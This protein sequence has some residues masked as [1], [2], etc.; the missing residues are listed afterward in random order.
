MKNVEAVAAPDTAVK[1]SN[2]SYWGLVIRKFRKNRLAIVSLWIL[3]IIVLLCIFVPL[4][5]PYGM[6]QTDALSREQPP[7]AAHWLGTDKIGRDMFTR[8]FYGGRI[9]LGVSLSVTGIQCFIG[10][11][12]GSIAGYYG[13]MADTIIMR[14]CEIFMSFPFMIMCIT[15]VAVFGSS[16]RTLI[17]ALAILQWPNIARIVRGQIL[18]LREQEYMEACEALGI[19]DFRRIFRHLFPNVLAYVI[20]YATLGMASAILVETSLSFLGLGV[21]PPTPTWG[22]MIT[23]AKDLL[24][25][26]NKWWYWIPPGIC[27]FLSVMCFNILGDGLRDAIDPKMKR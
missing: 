10:I 4:I 21:A 18:V 19:S 2:E 14:L 17:F 22:N 6:E 16:V 20:V 13:K 27:I 5:S 11:I 8:L 3:A 12:L 7:S 25:I 24:V 1:V 9:S 15:I 26:K 23:E